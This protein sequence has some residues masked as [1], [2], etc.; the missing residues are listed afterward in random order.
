MFILKRRQGKHRKISWVWKAQKD[1][2]RSWGVALR[3]M[4][5]CRRGRPLGATTLTFIYEAEDKW[6]VSFFSAWR[7]SAVIHLRVWLYPVRHWTADSH[8]IHVTSQHLR[9]CVK[10]IH[11][12]SGQN[13]IGHWHST[14]VLNISDEQIKGRVR[15][16]H[17]HIKGCSVTPSP[18][19]YLRIIS[20]HCIIYYI[21]QNSKL[22]FFLSVFF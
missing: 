20:A 13:T 8:P 18:S 21:L 3:H 7:L 22:G 9:R 15:W 17:T 5:P 12:R 11:R 1:L 10:F 4:H 19:L 14:C 16:Y 6:T 2:A